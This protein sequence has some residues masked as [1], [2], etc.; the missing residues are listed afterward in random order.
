MT[1]KR[2][3]LVK[4]YNE[5]WG[6]VDNSLEEIKRTTKIAVY[7]VILGKLEKLKENNQWK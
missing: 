1:E 4:C 5:Q 2:F 6:V 3:R 7:Q